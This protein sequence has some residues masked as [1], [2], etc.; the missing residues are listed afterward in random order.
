MKLGPDPNTWPA[1]TAPCASCVADPMQWAQRTADGGVTLYCPH[2]EALAVL[3][4]Y[5]MSGGGSYAMWQVF[6]PLPQ[7][8]FEMWLGD[9]PSL[10]RRWREQQ[11]KR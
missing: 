10:L 1:P 5:P 3:G 6:S 2:T 11:A 7:V 9:R 8:G 4:M